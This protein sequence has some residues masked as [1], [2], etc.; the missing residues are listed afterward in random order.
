MQSYYGPW[1][2]RFLKPSNVN[3]L[4]IACIHVCKHKIWQKS[5]DNTCVNMVLAWQKCHMQT[6][7]KIHQRVPKIHTVFTHLIFTH[8][9]LIFSSKNIG[10][11]IMW[12]IFGR[13][14]FRDFQDRSGIRYPIHKL[15]MF[16]HYNIGLMFWRG[17]LKSR[18]P[19]GQKEV[20]A[21]HRLQYEWVTM[22]RCKIEGWEIWGKNP[23]KTLE[24]LWCKKYVMAKIKWVYTVWSS[25]INSWS[26]TFVVVAH[27][28][29]AETLA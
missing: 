20:T 6:F 28:K 23:L 12:G 5:G 18:I 27:S 24:K 21:C 26:S 17:Q 1:L 7:I 22:P 3:V 16:Q 19:E 15:E 13:R 2:W 10:A 29:A 8:F 25:L 14:C 11:I 9:C 4:C